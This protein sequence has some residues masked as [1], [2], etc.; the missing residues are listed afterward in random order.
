MTVSGARQSIDILEW[1]MGGFDRRYPWQGAT[2]ERQDAAH[3]S[4]NQ[5]GVSAAP[6]PS[7]RTRH[8]RVWLLITTIAPLVALVNMLLAD[9][10]AH[11]PALLRSFLVVGL[12]VPAATSVARPPL[13]C[14]ARFVGQER[15]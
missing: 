4:L 2:V 15:R 10:I 6:Q 11:L 7:L 14:L 8:L 12:V 9:T 13:T 1:R 3:Q 5:E